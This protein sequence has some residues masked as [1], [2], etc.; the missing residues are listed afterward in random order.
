ME[1]RHKKIL[2]ERVRASLNAAWK[3]QRK[4]SLHRR[5]DRRTSGTKSTTRANK[6]RLGLTVGVPWVEK[7]GM[8]PSARP[9]PCPI[10]SS[11]SKTTSFTE[12]RHNESQESTMSFSFSFVPK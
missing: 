1:N 4:S 9:L 7:A 2:I 12:K 11:Q 8:G 10:S 5:A 6:G 3:R